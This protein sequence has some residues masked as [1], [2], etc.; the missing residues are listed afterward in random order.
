MTKI[1][2]NVAIDVGFGTAIWVVV[3]TAIAFWVC[4]IVL[5]TSAI[6][7]YKTE[8]SPSKTQA[9]SI[10]WHFWIYFEGICPKIK[11]ASHFEQLFYEYGSNQCS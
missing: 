2:V 9:A 3:W 4:A 8:R 6:S 7:G 10:L 11:L 5:K 1:S